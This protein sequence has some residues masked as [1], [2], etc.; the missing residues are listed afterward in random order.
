MGKIGDDLTNQNSKAL[1]VY[2]NVFNKS[3]KD[4]KVLL[5]P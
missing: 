5:L 1:S 2:V 4:W 3:L